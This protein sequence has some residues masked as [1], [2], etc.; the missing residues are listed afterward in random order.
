MVTSYFNALYDSMLHSW[1]LAI[2]QWIECDIAFKRI[3]KVIFNSNRLT[4]KSNAKHNTNKFQNLNYHFGQNAFDL[5]NGKSAMYLNNICKPKTALEKS[6]VFDDCTA[7]WKSENI[8]FERG[9]EN[10]NLKIDESCA[11][12]GGIGSGKSTILQVILGELNVKHGKVFV[13]GSI[14]YASQEAW[15]FSGTFQ[16]NI[17]F[18]EPFDALRY[19]QVIRVCALER[20]LDLLPNGNGTMIGENGFTL[21]GG[22]RSRISLARAVYRNADIYL[23]DDPLSALD[24]HVSKHIFDKCLHGFLKSKIVILV[25][26]QHQYLRDFNKIVVMRKGKAIAQGNSMEIKAYISNSSDFIEEDDKQHTQMH[27]QY[28]ISVKLNAFFC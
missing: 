17:L 27:S 12:I 15:L 11:I 10:L 1:P 7:L 19:A 21:S 3:E 16:E 22:Q 28:P 6:V 24:T 2:T 8:K 20:D 13:N 18:N 26:H 5:F 4:I 25:T 9:I 23:L 14:S